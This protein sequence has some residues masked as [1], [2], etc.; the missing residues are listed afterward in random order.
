MTRLA[1]AAASLLVGLAIAGPTQA[2][3][4]GQY[5]GL[6]EDDFEV[7][8]LSSDLGRMVRSPDRAFADLKRALGQ[9]SELGAAKQFMDED[10]D[11]MPIRVQP[12]QNRSMV[13]S[14]K[15]VKGSVTQEK[16][17]EQVTQAMPAPASASVSPQSKERSVNCIRFVPSASTTIS[18]DCEE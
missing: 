9:K 8:E 7:S 11:E 13:A 10:D 18:I 14:S 3:S 5:L 1:L 12:R 15:A 4:L 16:S 6:D 17:S 2:G